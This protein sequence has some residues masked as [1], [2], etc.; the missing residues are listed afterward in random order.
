MRWRIVEQIAIEVPDF[1]MKIKK[2]YIIEVEDTLFHHDSGVVLPSQPEGPSSVGG[3]EP[4]EKT[5]E[6]TGITVI[7]TI[8]EFIEQNPDKHLIIAGHT[9]TT[10]KP[11]Y[12]FELSMYRAS[13]VLYLLIGNKDK[14]AAISDKKHKVEDYQQ[15]LKH[16][17]TIWGWNCDLEKIDDKL[18]PKTKKAVRQFQGIYNQEFG[19]DILVDG[20]F[21]KQTWSAIFDC[22]VKELVDMLKTTP[23]GLDYYRNKIKFVSGGYKIL[24][25]GESYPIEEKEK[26]NYRSQTNRRVEV[27]FFDPREAPEI[28]CPDPMGPYN[29]QICN[30]DLC[31]IYKEGLYGFEYIKP[32]PPE[33]S[34]WIEIILKDEDDNPMPNEKFIL[35][36]SG[37]EPING[38]LNE[39]GRA[40]LTNIPPGDHAEIKFPNHKVI[41]SG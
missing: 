37:S 27:I 35:Y 21:G 7:A 28:N 36:I 31:P 11:K 10:G 16:Y 25:C 6:I 5:L 8:Y 15:I 2:A 23:E 13:S 17:A 34:N 14:W 19:E 39:D 33:S 1:E 22:Y 29:N 18:G 4:S 30:I 26:D 32:E 3:A 24:A 12:N 40:K 38:R 41:Q 9:D 20:V